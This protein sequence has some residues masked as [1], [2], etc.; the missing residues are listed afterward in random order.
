MKHDPIPG[1]APQVTEPVLKSDSFQFGHWQVETRTCSLRHVHDGSETQVE[2]RAMDVL[3]VLCHRAGNI[4]SA[5]D[6]LHLCWDGLVVGENQVHKAITQLRRALRDSVT[7]PTYIENIRKRGYRTL[8]PVSFP[9]GHGLAPPVDHWSRRSPYVGLNPFGADHRSVFCGRDGAVT[10]LS[11]AVAAQVAVGRAFTLV[12]GPSGSG[13]TSLIQAGLLPAL[14]HGPGTVRVA[15]A[16]GLD[17]GDAGDVPLATALGGTLLDLEVEGAPLFPG[18]NA[19]ALGS[20]LLAAVDAGLWLSQ[21]SDPRQVGQRFALFIDRLEAL[22]DPTVD[23]ARGPLLAALDRLARTDRFVVISACRNDFYADLARE[24]YLM[25]GKETGGHFDLAP[26]TR[27][28]IMQMIRSPAAIADLRFGIDTASD[29]RLDDILCDG[30]AD[31]PDALPLLQYTLEQLYQQRSPGRELTI[32]AYHGLGGIDGAIGRRADAILAD[33][34]PA[35]QAALPRIFSLIVALGGGDGAPRGLRA[36]WSALSGPNERRLVQTFVDERLFVSRMHGAEP[37][38][39]VAHE[40]LLRQWP[41]AIAWITEHHQALRIRARL[42][43]EAQQWLVDGRR[44]DRLL[45]RG[46]PLAEAV[47]LLTVRAVPLSAEVAAL[48]NASSRQARRADRLRLG[49]V[50]GFALVALVAVV[51]GFQAR[52]AE[53]LAD[54]RRQEAEGLVDFMLGDLTQKLQPLAK[55]DLMGGVAEKALTYLTAE[56]PGRVPGPLRLRQAKALLTLADV[57]RSRG[58]VDAALTALGRAEAL[59]NVNL[60]EGPVNGELLKN[61]GA[62]AFWFG[63]IALDRGQLDEAAARFG[64]YRDHAQRMVDISSDDADAWVELSYALSSLGSLKA[65]R[66]AEGD[67]IADFKRSIDLKEKALDRQGGDPSLLAGIANGLSWLAHSK[68]QAGD[69]DEA[70]SLYDRQ[71]EKLEN[72]LLLEPLATNWR[73]RLALAVKLKAQVLRALG[74]DREALADIARATA[75]LDECLLKEPDNQL[76]LSDR[77]DTLLVK[78]RA[79]IATQA[80][81][82][83]AMALDA[84]MADIDQASRQDSADEIILPR[85]RANALLLRA[86]IQGLKGRTDEALENISAAE[87]L[88]PS[89][90]GRME[91]DKLRAIIHANI[92]LARADL[93]RQQGKRDRAIPICRQARDRLAPFVPNS[94]DFRLLDPWVRAAMCSGD[95][96]TAAGSAAILKETGYRESMYL[97]N[98]RRQ[99]QETE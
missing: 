54:Q 6:L 31:N 1:A 22:F 70:A 45:R 26:P 87:S 16:A 15:A 68:A 12:L 47:E 71:R 14:L 57:N 90:P 52:T 55:L 48:I 83:G 98:I 39:G 92:L 20:G 32:T 91:N 74:N 58:N 96:E 85:L 41:R 73:Y 42:E 82:E 9:P 76:W 17:L 97:N 19:E 24:P 53:Q 66:G 4:L 23:A 30:V 67:A 3:S 40:A 63:Q 43:G 99:E 75:L 21:A 77:A 13:K 79:L 59:L 33:L 56:D 28:E 60:A 65:R 5:D 38:F 95:Q 81:V 89:L 94:K 44:A 62:V 18:W 84:A 72:L 36:P 78:A 93:E 86:H 34:P 80:V 49:A 10:R 11:A 35:A 69:L 88:V 37:V 27:A 8:A 2:P 50:A 29:T 61:A 51:M 7:Q 25:A 64:Q 46:R